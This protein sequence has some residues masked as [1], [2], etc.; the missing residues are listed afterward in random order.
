M[1]LG[2]TIARMKAC[3]MSAEDIVRALECYVS[4]PQRVVDEQAE[5]RRAADRARKAAKREAYIPQNS[6]DSAEKKEKVF[7]TFPKERKNITTRAKPLKT[8][9]ADDF[10]PNAKTWAVADECGFTEREV[11]AEIE[12]MRDWAKN[13]DGSKGRKTDWDAALRNWLKRAANDRRQPRPQA[14]S[15]FTRADSFAIADAVIDEAIRRAD[16]YGAEGGEEDTFG[17]PGLRKSAA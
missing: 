9:L 4:V 16:G 15:K 1:D 6:A 3:G 17:I 5:R 14:S 7:Q 13:A 8:D 12:K 11:F 10:Q 2:A